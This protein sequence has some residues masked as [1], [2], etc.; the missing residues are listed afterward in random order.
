[1]TKRG[2]GRIGKTTG[3]K[4]AY[5]LFKSKQ[6]PKAPFQVDYKIYRYLCEEFNKRVVDEILINA[7]EFRVPH[8]LGHIRIKKSAMSYSKESRLKVDWKAT[9]EAGQKIYHLNDHR[10]NYNYRWYWNKAKARVKHRR[11]YSFTATRS[12][13]RR[14]AKILLT[15]Y[16]ID[17]FE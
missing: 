15:D 13:K 4:E 2:K 9:K 11:V 6:N 1:M 12:N 7:R 17:Y 14:L 3:L 5:K 10:D 16:G 8:E